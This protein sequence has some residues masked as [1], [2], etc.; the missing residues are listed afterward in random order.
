WAERGGYSAGGHGKSGSRFQI[1]WGAGRGIVAPFV[2]RVR[3]HMKNGRVDYLPRHR[4]DDLIRQNGAV[5]GASGSIVEPSSAD[6]G[7]SSS[8][9][10]VGDFVYRAEAV[11]VASGGIGGN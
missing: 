4:V 8:R 2:S 5:V 3:E 10:V 11:V 9:K 6:R 7:E 1:V